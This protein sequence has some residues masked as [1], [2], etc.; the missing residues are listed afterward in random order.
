MSIRP[1]YC[2]R[3]IAFP[4]HV[5]WE[6]ILRYFINLQYLSP[7]YLIYT[8][9]A[10]TL[11][12]KLMRINCFYYLLF[13]FNF[14]LQKYLTLFWIVSCLNLTRTLFFVQVVYFLIDFQSDLLVNIDDR[15]T[16]WKR[17]D[18]GCS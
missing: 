14:L 12:P 3:I 10:F 2:Y 15:D 18:K 13:S 5:R 4:L 16:F 8:R 1:N 7:I 9:C 17:Q 11:D 6:Y